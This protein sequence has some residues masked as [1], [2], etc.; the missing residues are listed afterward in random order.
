MVKDD[1]PRLLS[2]D[3]AAA[4][5]KVSHSLIY[6]YVEQMRIPHIKIGGR[7]RFDPSALSEWISSRAVKVVNND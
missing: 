3:D 5:L 6:K 4:Y 2:V 1:K 7:I